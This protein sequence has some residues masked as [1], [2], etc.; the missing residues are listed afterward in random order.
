MSLQFEKRA[1]RHSLSYYDPVDTL[2]KQC[3]AKMLEKNRS[4]DPMPRAS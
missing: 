2:R 3:N 1:P 4:A